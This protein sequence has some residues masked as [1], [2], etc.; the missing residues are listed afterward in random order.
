MLIFIA[1][2]TVTM[3]D[4]L[5][6]F[7][8]HNF[9]DDRDTINQCNLFSDTTITNTSMAGACPA[10]ANRQCVKYCV[11][12]RVQKKRS[13]DSGFWNPSQKIKNHYI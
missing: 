9:N 4:V 1:V 13:L 3:R 10:R 7:H 6:I 2:Y 12:L 11:I 8:I 5:T